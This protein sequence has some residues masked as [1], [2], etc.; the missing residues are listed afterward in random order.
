MSDPWPTRGLVRYLIW[1]EGWKKVEASLHGKSQCKS[2][3]G[4]AR[5]WRCSTRGSD[6]SEKGRHAPASLES[7]AFGI[8][9]GARGPAQVNPGACRILSRTCT[10]DALQ[11]ARE[12][13]RSGRICG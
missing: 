13:S 2:S 8:F 5:A 6:K 4:R 10:A 12:S 3:R 11:I 9:G 7:H 1:I